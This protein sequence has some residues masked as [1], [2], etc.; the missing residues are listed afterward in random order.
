MSDD[1][2]RE[3]ERLNFLMD[4]KVRRISVLLSED[5]VCDGMTK[6]KHVQDEQVVP[7]LILNDEARAF[8]KGTRK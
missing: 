4:Q 7:K 3:S 8:I 2:D 5:D 1:V 6:P